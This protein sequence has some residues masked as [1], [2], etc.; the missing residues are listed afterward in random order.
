MNQRTIAKKIELIGIGL[1]K[2][3]PV[4]MILSLSTTILSPVKIGIVVLD[5]MARNTLLS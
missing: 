1:H 2:G 5:E 3:V 4:K